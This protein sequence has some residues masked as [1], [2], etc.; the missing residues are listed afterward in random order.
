MDLARLPDR[1]VCG[2]KM[3]I[4][5]ALN[6]A[7]GGYVI[8]RHNAVRDFLAEQLSDVCADVQVEPPLQPLDGETFSSQAAAT[9]EQARPDIR[10]RGFFRDGQQAFFDVKLLNPNSDSYLKTP[11]VKIY[12][13]AER[14]KKSL[15]NERIQHVERGTFAPLIFSVTGGMGPESRHFT[16]LLCRK[17]ADKHKQEYSYVTNFVKCKLSFL[18][19]KLVLLCV[20]GSRTVKQSQHSSISESDFQ[21]GCF[22]SKLLTI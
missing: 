6:C 14:A 20:R 7:R 1:C 13:R 11:T 12:E 18:I 15:Y 17:L 10:A 5:H 4:T 19:R 2:D 22:E 9:G 21:F 16:K 3:S 8:I